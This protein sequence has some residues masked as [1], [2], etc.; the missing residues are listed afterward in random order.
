[1][2]A[3]KYL[4]RGYT[5]LSV[6]HDQLPRS[7]PEE[8]LRKGPWTVGE[9]SILMEYINIH[10]EGRWNL[11]VG[12]SGL[13]RSGKSC[14]LRWLNYLR[15]NVRRGNITLQEQLLI[16]QL[17]S[18][19]GN[20]WSKIAEY[21]PGR[22]DN[23]IK[24]YWR[25]RVQKQAKQLNCD[26]NSKRF[27]EAMRYVW[28]PRLMER[29]QSSIDS[30]VVSGQTTATATATASAFTPPDGYCFSDQSNTA[31]AGSSQNYLP[32]ASGASSSSTEFNILQPT[33]TKVSELDYYPTT[34]EYCSSTYGSGNSGCYQDGSQ[35]QGSDQI[36]SSNSWSAPGGDLEENLW[37]EENIWFLQQ[38]L[39]ND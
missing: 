24:N 27:Q 26:V 4:L 29:I 35:F 18:R 14:R 9:D 30:T 25:T 39:N 10:G 22:T 15:P 19:W 34:G 13:K 36:E 2:D 16:L 11:L 12:N 21:L 23:E 8:D 17:H 20:R 32:V 1:M 6:T 37:N 33:R 31:A 5:S 3:D 7:E 28:I 38:Q